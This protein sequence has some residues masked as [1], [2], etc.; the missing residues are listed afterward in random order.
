MTSQ[1]DSEP[2]VRAG[3]AGGLG[4]SHTVG[5]NEAD[6]GGFQRVLSEA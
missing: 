3:W 2:R 6:S 1:G 5:E 4:V